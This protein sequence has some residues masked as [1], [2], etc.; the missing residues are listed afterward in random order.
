MVSQE[1]RGRYRDGLVLEWSKSRV[2]HFSL[3]KG[4]FRSFRICN[5][6]FHDLVR[7]EIFFPVHVIRM[8][9][10]LYCLPDDA[11][12]ASSPQDV[13]GAWVAIATKNAL[14]TLADP[15]Y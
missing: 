8:E 7:G 4:I 1:Q 2:S 10:D 6:V 9:L 13:S 15:V 14:E 12:H 11:F 5:S 3:E